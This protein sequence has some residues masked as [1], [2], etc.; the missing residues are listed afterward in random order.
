MDGRP[1][2]PNR[3]ASPITSHISQ[4]TPLTDMHDSHDAAGMMVYK[5]KRPQVQI[6]NDSDRIGP[7]GSLI[8]REIHRDRE[9]ESHADAEVAPTSQR[10]VHAYSTT[11][12]IHTWPPVAG[13]AN[14][15]HKAT[16][17]ILVLPTRH[18]KNPCIFY[19][20]SYLY[21][22]QVVVGLR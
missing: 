9:N 7:S 14:T 20:V 11:E 16:D 2:V 18:A 8:H 5:S 3:V 1:H 10:D 4:T 19:L 15:T 22:S 21:T 12:P 13:P 6:S 17:A